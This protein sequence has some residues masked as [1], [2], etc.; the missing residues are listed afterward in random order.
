MAC[1][2]GCGVGSGVLPKSFAKHSRILTKSFKSLP[3][4]SNPYQILM[5]QKTGTLRG[6]CRVDTIGPGTPPVGYARGWPGR[7]EF[8][9]RSGCC[10]APPLSPIS[11]Q[12][13]QHLRSI[14]AT[15]LQHL[16]RA[17]FPLGSDDPSERP[18]ILAESSAV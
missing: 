9:S 13:L 15:S 18:E 7:R 16:G 4:P 1:G 10:F 14:S 5:L 11:L 17:V 8:I 6:G 3:N 12:S 2:G